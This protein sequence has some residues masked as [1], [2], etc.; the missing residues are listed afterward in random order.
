MRDMKFISWAQSV[1]CFFPETAQPLV[2][3]QVVILS[4]WQCSELLGV[5]VMFVVHRWLMQLN[6]KYWVLAAAP[7]L[8]VKLPAADP[9][10]KICQLQASVTFGMFILPNLGTNI[11]GLSKHLHSSCWNEC[12]L[13]G[14]GYDPMTILNWLQWT[15]DRDQKTEHKVESHS[16]LRQNTDVYI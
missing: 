8:K 2:L 1:N 3:G 13:W 10:V 11:F 14:C 5:A 9:L 15:S 6:S 16:A 4:A 12:S 7:A